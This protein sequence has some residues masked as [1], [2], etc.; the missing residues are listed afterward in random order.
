MVFRN[1]VLPIQDRASSA[2]TP[3]DRALIT[4][5]QRISKK[6]P[7]RPKERPKENRKEIKLDMSRTIAL[8]GSGRKWL[9]AKSRLAGIPGEELPDQFACQK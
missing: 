6:N 5:Y 8:R 7:I 1:A 2:K 3:R 4:H 9:A